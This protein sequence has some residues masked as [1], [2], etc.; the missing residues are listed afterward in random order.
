MKKELFKYKNLIKFVLIILF[1]LSLFFVVLYNINEYEKKNNNDSVVE[2]S[3]SFLNDSSS[4]ELKESNEL[5][6]QEKVLN[7]INEKLNSNIYTID[8]PLIVIDPFK[9]NPLSAIIA[10]NTNEEIEINV[11]IN[12]EYRYISK[13]SSTHVIPIFYLIP[14]DTNIITLNGIE[15][16]LNINYEYNEINNTNNLLF[17]LNDKLYIYKY[18][19]LIGLIDKQI[20]N[21]LY[22]SNG[23]ILYLSNNSLYEITPYGFIT[24]I[25]H[26]EYKVMDFIENNDFLYMIT[27]NNLVIKFNIKTKEKEI[28]NLNELLNTESISLSSIDFNNGKVVIGVNDINSVVFLNSN[29]ELLYIFGNINDNF[30]NYYLKTNYNTKYLDSITSLKYKDDYLY[31]IDNNILKIYIVNESNKTIRLYKRVN[32]EATNITYEDSLVLNNIELNKYYRVINTIN[33]TSKKT[34]IKQGLVHTY[35]ESN[36]YFDPINIESN[37]VDLKELSSYAKADTFDLDITLSNNRLII[38]KSFDIN[39]EVSIILLDKKG[40]S[41]SYLIKN[42]GKDKLN[43]IDISLLNDSKYFIYTKVNTK[44]YNSNRY[45]N[46]RSI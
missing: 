20:D 11:S 9:V 44:V 16:P 23:N 27:S 5:E 18:N 15:I 24:D 7:D 10:F 43:Y 21:Y 41:Y 45:V 25:I 12:N 26:L 33:I 1:L 30:K 35:K 32:I 36:I 17:A 4:I 37:K 34:I 8:N 6:S 31:V 28:V 19:K 3:F 14:N 38:N 40:F 22:L 46:K 2:E 39:D 13:K 42:S 29:L